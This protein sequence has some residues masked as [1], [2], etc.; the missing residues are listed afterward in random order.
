MT[1]NYNKGFD[2]GVKIA[3]ANLG[4]TPGDVVRHSA[5]S[6][7]LLNDESA[8]KDICK[9][10]AGIFAA[11]DMADSV[12]YNLFDV[13]SKSASKLSTVSVEKFIVP[14]LKSLE[15]QAKVVHEELMEKS[16]SPSI[17]GGLLAKTVGAG[18]SVVPELYKL[19]ALLG[20]GA[21][22]ATGALTWYLNRDANQDDAD[23][24]AKEEQAKHYTQIAKDIKKRLNLEDKVTK[25]TIEDSAEDQGEGAYII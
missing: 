22:T 12:E 14:V 5:F 7:A 11:A 16:A 15:K 2:A 19:Y 9:V 4:I 20:A 13:M 24:E 17:L 1:V 3:C 8:Q 23:I 18:T 25:K 21:G 6:D 10:A